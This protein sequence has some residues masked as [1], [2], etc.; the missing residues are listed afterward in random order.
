MSKLPCV[1]YLKSRRSCKI[2]V[3]NKCTSL[4]KFLALGALNVAN[5]V[6]IKRNKHKNSLPT[7]PI[8][9]WHE[10]WNMHIFLYLALAAH[11]NEMTAQQLQIFV[12]Y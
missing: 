10:T 5:M 7:L 11:T 2:V 4:Y 3:P 9:F 12:E 8:F 1:V 6:N